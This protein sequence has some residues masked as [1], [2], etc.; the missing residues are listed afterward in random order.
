MV[1][2]GLKEEGTVRKK[3]KKKSPPP[4]FIFIMRIKKILDWLIF[5]YKAMREIKK[6]IYITNPLLLDPT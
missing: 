4:P 2:N 3:E 5:Q 1:R 6:F